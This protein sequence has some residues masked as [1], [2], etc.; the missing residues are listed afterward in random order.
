M[1]IKKIITCKVLRTVP[2]MEKCHINP[3]R[4]PIR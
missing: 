2:G 1:K 4:F 3:L